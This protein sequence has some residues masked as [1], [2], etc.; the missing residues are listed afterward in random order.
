M[1]TPNARMV[2]VPNING[3]C[4]T[5]FDQVRDAFV[6]NFE[7]RGE[8]GASVAIFLEGKAVVDLWGGYMDAQRTTPWHRDTIVNV[9]SLGKAMTA[10]AIMKAVEQGYLALEDT[11]ATHWPEFK[12]QDKGDITVATALA[13]RAGLS[14][15]ER[16]LPNDA[17]FDWNLMTSTI[18]AQKP[19]WKPGTH[20][21]YHTNTFGFLLGETLRRAT[22]ERIRDFFQDRI[23]QPLGADFFMGIPA[24]EEHRVATLS[25]SPRPDDARNPL[26]QGTDTPDEPLAK[27]RQLVYTNPPILFDDEQAGIN[28][29]AW[30][31]AEFPSTSPQSNARSVAGIFGHLA[32]IIYRDEPGIIDAELIKRATRIASDGEDLVVQRPTRF[33]LG[34]QLTQPDRPLGPNSDTFGHYGNGGH[35]G[36]ADPTIPLGFAYHMNLQGYAWR[37]P[38]NIAL[39]DA[40]YACLT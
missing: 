27:M 20:H 36:F 16:P 29:R 30:R 6:E 13:H 7:S 23:A 5:R 12:Q 32:D 9:W 34:F 37:D 10:L 25:Q 28:S 22:G 39:T 31:M 8:I 4:D 19:W 17:F 40:M 24:S 18:A 15:L 11:I 33:G 2:N 14:A 3:Y 26:A 38:R 35:I 1:N 21:G